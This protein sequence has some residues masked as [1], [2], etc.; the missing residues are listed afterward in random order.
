M[1]ELALYEFENP[2]VWNI[3]GRGDQQMIGSKPFAKAALQ[4]FTRELANRFRSAQN[5]ATERMLGPEAACKN[6]VQQRFR[7]VEIHLDL[8][9]N[10]LALLCHVFGIEKRTETQVG[11]DVESD[12]EMV[13]EHLCVEA[14]LLF[15]RE[16]VEHA[17]DGIH[18]AGDGFG[19]A[20]LGAF[21]D[22][23]LHEMGEAVLLRGFAAGAVANPDTDRY[24]ADMAH[25]LG[26]DDETVGQSV[27]LDVAL[28]SNH[29]EIVTHGGRQWR[30]A[31]PRSGK[32]AKA[33]TLALY[34][35]FSPGWSLPYSLV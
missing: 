11:N 16:G 1:A 6:F 26:H 13:V 22:H 10:Y 35:S 24:G 12:G 5:R 17:A 14:N 29:I 23:V 2:F 7:I 30:V 28:F 4:R 15:R 33:A 27:P 3:A 21:E 18:F 31:S 34:R 19:G 8:F 25:G 20:A 32:M 9:E